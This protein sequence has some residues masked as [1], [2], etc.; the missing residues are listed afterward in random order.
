MEAGIFA[1]KREEL[2]GREEFFSG[3][4]RQNKLFNNQELFIN[5]IEE[6]ELE[7]LIESLEKT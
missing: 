6:I 5:N 7:K 3:N 2:L 4:V 1:S